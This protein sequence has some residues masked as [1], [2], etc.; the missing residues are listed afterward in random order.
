M[1]VIPLYIFS[2]NFKNIVFLQRPNIIK[3]YNGRLWYTTTLN[4]CKTWLNVMQELECCLAYY[5]LNRSFD[6]SSV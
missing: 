4:T 1:D 3:E 2:G 5:I 6:S